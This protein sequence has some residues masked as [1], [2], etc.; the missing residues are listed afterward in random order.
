MTH[1]VTHD[2]EGAVAAV[3]GDGHL[4][5]LAAVGEASA[6]ELLW[7]SLS[8]V[9]R[10]PD[11]WMTSGQDWAFEIM[12]AARRAGRSVLAGQWVISATTC[13]TV[14]IFRDLARV[15]LRRNARGGEGR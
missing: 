12:L 11:K 2:P 5:L 4:L 3:D 8:C 10:G 1:L 14:P 6:R 9:P 7:A 15:M 13:R